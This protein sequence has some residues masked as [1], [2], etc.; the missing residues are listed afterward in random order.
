MAKTAFSGPLIS[1]GQSVYTPNE[2]NPDLGPCMMYAG[3]GILDPRT[4]F[5]YNP[6]QGDHVPVYAWLGTDGVQTLSIVPY[7]K[8]TGAVVASAD[9]TS[10]ALALV[11]ANSSTTG[12]YITPSIT[13]SDTGVV[14][15]GV[16][17]NGLVVLDAYASITASI[18]AGVMTV[19]ANSTMPISNGM[20]LLTSAGTV[21]AGTVLG[22][23][24]VSQLTAGTGGM[25]VAGTYQLNNTGL[26]ATS[27][28]VTL[29]YQ[30]PQQ[31][32]VPFGSVP[33]PNTGLA[34]G[35]V[36]LWNPQALV[37]RALAVTAASGA[38]YTTATIAGYDIYGYPMVESITL[39]AGSQVAG[40]KAWKYV[41]SVTLSGGTADT[42]HAYSVDTTDVLGFPLRSDNFGDIILN[43]ATSLTGVTLTTAVTNYLPSDRTTATATTGDVRGTYANFTSS[44]GANKLTLRQWPAPGNIGS[45]AGLFG[46]TQYANF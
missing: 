6:G 19:T 32:I 11:S 18:T 7:T 5:T 10:A 30:N 41:R 15:T 27:G 3:Q 1:F 29:A 26:T 22:T 2:Y 28:T 34:T 31:C 24:I 44:T 8:A 21:S 45:I 9:P 43:N 20:T 38:T 33:N 12:V 14:D 4:P 42:T 35:N 23:Q 25:G 16:G 36:N 13:R 17:G 46:V 37:G 40:K 39:S